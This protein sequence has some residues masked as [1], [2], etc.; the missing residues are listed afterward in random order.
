MAYIKTAGF[1][2]GMIL[3]LV[4]VLIFAANVD[5]IQAILYQT[6]FLNLL[7]LSFVCFLLAR[8]TT[9]LQQKNS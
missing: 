1:G 8:I 7:G 2:L 9:I 3:L 6:P 4:D 5:T